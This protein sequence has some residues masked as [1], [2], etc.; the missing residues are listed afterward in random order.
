LWGE[1]VSDTIFVY[2]AHARGTLRERDLPTEWVEATVL[3]PDA[4]EPDSTHP[5]RRRAY[6]A[7]PERDGRILRVVYVRERHICRIVTAFLDRGR[8]KRT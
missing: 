6:R 8:R 3:T 4:E 1:P 7:V 5:D 2:T